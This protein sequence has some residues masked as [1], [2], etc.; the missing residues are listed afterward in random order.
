MNGHERKWIADPT[1]QQ[2]VM[3][4]CHDDKAGM[5]RI[6]YCSYLPIKQTFFK[7]HTPQGDNT[8][9]MFNVSLSLPCT[10][11]GHFGRDKTLHKICFHLGTLPRWTLFGLARS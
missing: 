10:G 7:G 1:R 9:A 6:N 4:A 8:S 11:G 2:A 5:M 3:Q